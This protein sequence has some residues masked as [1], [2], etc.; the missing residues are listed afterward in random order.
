VRSFSLENNVV[1]L[2][3][4]RDRLSAYDFFPVNSNNSMRQVYSEDVNVSDINELYSVFIKALYKGL[5]LD[6]NV[7]RQGKLS[8]LKGS[9]IR[10]Q[11]E[12]I[13][14]ENAIYLPLGFKRDVDFLN[15]VV[16]LEECSEIYEIRTDRIIPA[17]FIPGVTTELTGGY[18][19]TD[20]DLDNSPFITSRRTIYRDGIKMAEFTKDLW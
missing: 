16:E 8:L 9:D 11:K 19:V 6:A 7:T 5:I 2:S 1:S 15:K 10:Q 13:D 18:T 3:T 12:V 20:Y 4:H 17:Y 14:K